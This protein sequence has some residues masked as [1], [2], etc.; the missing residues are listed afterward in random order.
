MFRLELLAFLASLGTIAC[1]ST[2][3]LPPAVL[4]EPAKLTLED[5]Q[6]AKIT[7]RLRNP[8]TPTVTW[9]SSNSAV[10]T[11]DIT[12]KVTGVT[13]GT[14]N[15]IVRM[16]D[17][18]TISATVPVTVSGPAVA[19]VSVSPPSAVVYVGFARQV[20]AQLRSADGRV[21]RGRLVTWTTPDAKIADVSGSGIVRGRGPGGPI[22]LVATSEG[23]AGTTQIRVAH[24]A[25]VCPFVTA[26]VLGQPAEGALALGDCEYS[27]DDS[28]VDVYEISLPAAGTIQID[29]T[30][31]DLDSYLGLFE[32]GGLFLAEDDN[33]GGGR[34]ARLVRQLPA[35]KYRIWANTISGTETGAYSLVVAQR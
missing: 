8:K 28:Y 23:H 18:S 34:N 6:S 16:T 2:R 26:L 11:V 30:S 27:L 1:E 14:T 31:G 21:I 10:A 32:S 9:A 15:I 24:A 13:N 7:A 29:M 35:G 22:A 20:V 3:P 12:G 4:V 25:E 17:D 5:G 19:T 33:S